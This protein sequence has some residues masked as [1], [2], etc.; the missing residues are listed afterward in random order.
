MGEPFVVVN[1]PPRP[2]TTGLADCKVPLRC[3]AFILLKNPLRILVF[4]LIPHLSRPGWL[5]ILCA[6]GTINSYS[7]FLHVQ[8]CFLLFPDHVSDTDL[9]VLSN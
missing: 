3:I 8:E 9:D 1:I 5:S 2:V 7:C 4:K 6:S